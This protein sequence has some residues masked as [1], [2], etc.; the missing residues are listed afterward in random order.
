[1]YGWEV[2]RQG[3]EPANERKQR[4]LTWIIKVNVI[5]RG[6]YGLDEGRLRGPYGNGWITPNRDEI[7]E[8]P[9]KKIK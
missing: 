6:R 1:M 4:I 2:R 7:K 8:N 3:V 5:T 9:G